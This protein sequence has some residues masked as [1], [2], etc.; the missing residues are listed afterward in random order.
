MIK[1]SNHVRRTKVN[2]IHLQII[3]HYFFGSANKKWTI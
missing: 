3:E 2:T 1:N